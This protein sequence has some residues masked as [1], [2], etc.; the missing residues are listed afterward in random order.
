ME[1]VERY[2][3]PLRR[4]MHFLS[5][6]LERDSGFSRAILA[7]T[8]VRLDGDRS[9]EKN[10]EERGRR[11]RARENLDPLIRLQQNIFYSPVKNG[12]SVRR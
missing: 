7:T 6:L 10:E 9:R 1:L 4:E 12:L 11:R 3:R 2:A 8:F 5:V